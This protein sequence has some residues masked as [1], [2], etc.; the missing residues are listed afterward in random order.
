MLNNYYRHC[1]ELLIESKNVNGSEYASITLAL[2]LLTSSHP[3]TEEALKERME[4]NDDFGQLLLSYGSL[5][6]HDNVESSVV[7]TLVEK[8]QKLLNSDVE[9]NATVGEIIHI[10]HAL[11]NAGSKQIVPYLIPFLYGFDLHLKLV[12]IDALRAVTREENVQQKFISIVN[13][14]VI[15]DPIIKVVQSMTFPF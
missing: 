13:S 2:A 11:G 10:I 12:S 15:E 9:A 5:G 8:L 7:M 4:S 1:R 14:A 6:R 3:S